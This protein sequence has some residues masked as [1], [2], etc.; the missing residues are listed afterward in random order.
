MKTFQLSEKLLNRI[1]D[2]IQ[3]KKDTQLKKLVKDIH[4]A[5]MAEIINELKKINKIFF[6]FFDKKKNII[7]KKIKHNENK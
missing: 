3:A 2:L 5:D 7:E 6:N 1:A 4:Y